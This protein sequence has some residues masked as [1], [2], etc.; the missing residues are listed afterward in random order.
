[1]VYAWILRD[2]PLA[3]AHYPRFKSNSLPKALITE[4]VE[5][6]H[7]QEPFARRSSPELSTDA[8]ESAQTPVTSKDLGERTRHAEVQVLPPLPA[9]AGHPATT[10]TQ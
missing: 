10:I 6:I 3:V 5:R 2:W 8:A 4:I 9:A 1:M 7:N